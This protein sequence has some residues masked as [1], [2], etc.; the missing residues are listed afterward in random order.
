MQ[1]N[2]VTVQEVLDATLSRVLRQTISTTGSG[3]TDAGVH[4]LQQF[5]HF[6]TEAPL[7]PSS[8]GKTVSSLN[9]LLPPDVAVRRLIPV[10]D[11]KSTRLNSSHVKISY[12][13]FCL[14]KKKKNITRGHTG[15]KL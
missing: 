10:S 1:P 4:A 13:V 6:D 7:P 3:R 14:K 8:V 15:S 12:A 9:A 11:R 2:A 5:A